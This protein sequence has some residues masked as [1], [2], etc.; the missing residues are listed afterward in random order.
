MREQG[1]D[2]LFGVDRGIVLPK[3][4]SKDVVKHYEKVIAKAMKNPEV[5]R[6]LEAKGS[7]VK[8]L[9]RK[10]YRKHL[11]NTFNA[12]RTTAIKVGLYKP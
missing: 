12:L 11:E 5:V 3:G 2:L 4:A 10:D 9:G 7:T 1:V 6:Q 8:Y